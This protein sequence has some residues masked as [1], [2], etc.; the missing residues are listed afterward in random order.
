MNNF[1]YISLAILVLAI[2]YLNYNEK[3]SPVSFKS[4]QDPIRFH[5]RNPEQ[6]NDLYYNGYIVPS[7][8]D[9]I[10]AK[11]KFIKGLRDYDINSTLIYTNEL[12]K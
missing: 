1:I 11:N 10:S 3:F 4:S 5:D 12:E 8:K 6:Y 9:N 7:I 2:V